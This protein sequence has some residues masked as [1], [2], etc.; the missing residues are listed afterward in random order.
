MRMFGLTDDQERIAK[1]FYKTHE[2]PIGTDIFGQKAMGAIG[3]G[4]TYTFTPT[5]LGIITK[6]VCAC[7]ANVDLTDFEDW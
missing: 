5:G 1:E 2:C 4:L 6:A 7:G 3:G